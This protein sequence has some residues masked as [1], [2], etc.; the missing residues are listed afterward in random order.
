M[1]ISGNATV[2]FENEEPKVIGPGDIFYVSNTPHDSWVVG[3]EDYVSIHFM[4]EKIRRLTYNVLLHRSWRS[5]FSN[6]IK[7]YR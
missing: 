4:G 7:C 5:T 2:A 1:V 3:D 6:K